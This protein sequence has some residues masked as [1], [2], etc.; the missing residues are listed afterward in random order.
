MNELNLPPAPPLPPEV[1]DRALRTVLEGMTAP[2]P[3]RG[4][5]WA[6]L[7]TAAAVVLVA[8][9]SV[10]VVTVS[11]DAPAGPAL[12][13]PAT[14]TPA[15]PP[16]TGPLLAPLPDAEHPAP[17]GDPATDAALARC[18]TA[19][20][21]SGHAADYP[22]TAEWHSTQHGGSGAVESQLTIDDS[23][24]CLVTPGS[25]AVSGTGKDATTGAQVVSMS[26]D[27]LVVLNPQ[28]RRFTLG[29]GDKAWSDT[30]RVTFLR[31]SEL[32]VDGAPVGASTSLEDLPLSVDGGY[33]GTVRD[34]V[35]AITV[36]DRDLP[37][38][39]DTPD[40]A[41][42][43]SCLAS[44]ESDRYTDPGLWVPVGRQ[45]GGGTA[46]GAIIARIGDVA[47]GF[48][49]DDPAGGPTFRGAPLPAPSDRPQRVL[50]YRG[51]AS[52]LLITAP[53]G[54]T[55]V[56]V[57]LAGGSGGARD[58]AIADGLAACVVNDDGPLSDPDGQDVVVTAYTT[59]APHGIQV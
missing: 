20:V 13:P 8:A 26:P 21:R 15:P 55:R 42:L 35:A 5:R 1:R 7:L 22:P 54:T 44:P 40:G 17:S 46:P 50:A 51:G 4:R 12:L 10:A 38:R 24:G 43:T 28:G 45:D 41:E 49:V 56:E 47:A 48:C 27:V 30:A 11:D 52:A 37:Q 58:C 19:V 33:T 29:S 32:Q 34:V 59:T 23:F 6:P 36:A 31:T 3:G 53:P 9:T 2:I 25:V 18:A 57:R 14:G 16:T 39:A